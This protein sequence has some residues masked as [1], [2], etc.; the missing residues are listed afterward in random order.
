MTY[1]VQGHVRAMPAWKENG[2]MHTITSLLVTTGTAGTM[3]IIPSS[4]WATMDTSK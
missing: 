3:D 4:V 2:I 1:L